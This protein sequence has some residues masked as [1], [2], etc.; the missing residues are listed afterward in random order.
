ML[1]DAKYA[2]NIFFDDVHQVA[3]LRRERKEPKPDPKDMHLYQTVPPT[4]ATTLFGLSDAV[5]T[6][7]YDQPTYVEFAR[8]KSVHDIWDQTFGC[9]P[10]SQLMT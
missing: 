4:N 1:E 9:P 3:R 2:R 5:K 10:L 6:L 8:R 7:A